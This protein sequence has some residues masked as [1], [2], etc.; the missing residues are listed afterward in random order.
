MTRPLSFLF[1]ARV[2]AE[3]MQRT[4]ILQWL[5]AWSDG[6]ANCSNLS[7]FIRISWHQRR[8]R[9]CL[10]QILHYG[11][12]FNQ[13]MTVDVKYW[14]VLHRIHFNFISTI[15]IAKSRRFHW[16]HLIWNVLEIK[17]NPDSIWAARSPRCMQYR[18]WRHNRT[19]ISHVTFH[20]RSSKH[21]D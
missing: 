12:W 21:S 4:S 13:N 9:S 19:I 2:F 1:L 7:S 17:A 14:N 15:F 6:I 5:N 18:W 20:P 11:Q 10:F 8:L 16:I 3:Q